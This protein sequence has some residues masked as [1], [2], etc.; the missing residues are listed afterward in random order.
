MTKT[1]ITPDP[2]SLP[3]PVD[4]NGLR[5]RLGRDPGLRME[6]T[7]GE[8]GDGNSGEGGEGEGEGGTG[9]EGEGST[10]EGEQ[11]GSET[12]AKTLESL[13]PEVQKLIRDARSENQRLRSERN[14][15]REEG[16]QKDSQLKAVLK[17]LG[18]EKDAADPDE[19]QKALAE[20]DNQLRSLK[21]ENAFG[22]V[23]KTHNADEALTLAVLSHKGALAGLDPDDAGF[24]KT[25]SDLVKAEVDS[26][27]KL[28]VG[29]A[30]TKSG[31]KMNGNKGGG[32]TSDTPSLEQALAAQL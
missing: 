25:L 5:I 13:P 11:T 17:A 20:R 12:E 30:P 23:A 31:N 3:Y 4:E 6:Y 15:A 16:T 32:R 9:G 19:L 18:L 14:S 21:V 26:N 7:G 8:G 2:I 29:Q 24:E 22:R 28:K 1:N 10:G 27:P